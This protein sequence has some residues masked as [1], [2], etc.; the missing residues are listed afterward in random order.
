MKMIK[1]IYSTIDK[2]NILENNNYKTKELTDVLNKN[3]NSIMKSFI[4]LLKEDLKNINE[5]HNKKRIK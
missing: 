2:I 5:Q 3:I 4:I 1:H